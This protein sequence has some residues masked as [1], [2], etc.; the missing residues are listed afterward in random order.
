MGEILPVNL[1]AILLFQ[2]IESVRVEFKASWD[3][4]NTG[5]DSGAKASI[6]IDI[7]NSRPSCSK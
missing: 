6:G 7:P 4:R 2:G 5:S 3:E 1:E